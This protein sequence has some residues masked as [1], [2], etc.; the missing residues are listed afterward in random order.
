MATASNLADYSDLQAVDGRHQ[1]SEGLQPL[2]PSPRPDHST[3]QAVQHHLTHDENGMEVVH[4]DD[5][6]NDP[7]NWSRALSPLEGKDVFVDYK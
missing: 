5:T 3:L 2:F 6:P 7:E 4:R 1:D